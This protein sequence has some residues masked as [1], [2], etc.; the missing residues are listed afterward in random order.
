MLKTGLYLQQPAHM[1]ILYWLAL[2]FLLGKSFTGK[3]PTFCIIIIIVVPVFGK[4]FLLI[5]L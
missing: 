3:E 4:N 2:T 5:A 1:T